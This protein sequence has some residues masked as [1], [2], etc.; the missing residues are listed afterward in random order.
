MATTKNLVTKLTT[1]REDG[2]LDPEIKQFG[3][4]FKNVV[5]DR[6]SKGNYT[7]AQFFDNYD[8][9]MK[10]SFFVYRGSTV[11]DNTRIALWI[12]TSTNNQAGLDLS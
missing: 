11:P 7:L 8:A 9:F 5:D 4:T 10:N 3:V 2:T 12:D 6:G 1:K